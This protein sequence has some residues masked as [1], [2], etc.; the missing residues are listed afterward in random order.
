MSRRGGIGGKNLDLADEHPRAD[1]F[2]VFCA[3]NVAKTGHWVIRRG[4]STL[5]QTFADGSQGYLIPR[6][7][8][9]RM[10]VPQ[11]RMQG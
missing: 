7:P 11:L 8:V 10:D 1:R 5:R 2:H 9:G 3:E 4:L 6:G